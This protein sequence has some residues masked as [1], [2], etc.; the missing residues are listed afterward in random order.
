MPETV[1][2]AERQGRGAKHAWR[3]SQQ[4]RSHRSLTPVCPCRGD[5]CR[6][7]VGLTASALGERRTIPPTSGKRRWSLGSRP[8]IPSSP[9]EAGH[10]GVEPTLESSCGGRSLGGFWATAPRPGSGLRGAPTDA[11]TRPRHPAPRGVLRAAPHGGT[12][13]RHPR[14][15]AAGHRGPHG[16]GVHRI[17]PGG[18][19]AQ[20]AKATGNARGEADV[21]PEAWR[22]EA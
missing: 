4:S 8:G 2:P 18:G 20:A 21:R 12:A 14:S 22:E 5:A 19:R 9:A 10:T 17:R 15:C 6:P 16:A 13:R 11:R 3:G 1:V 7:G